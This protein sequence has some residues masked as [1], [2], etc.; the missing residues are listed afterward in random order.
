MIPRTSPWL[1]RVW[2]LGTDI[3]HLPAN[4]RRE[5]EPMVVAIREKPL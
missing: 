4:K 2:S 5:L 3:D 1:E